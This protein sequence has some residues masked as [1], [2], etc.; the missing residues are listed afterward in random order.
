MPLVNINNRGLKLKLKF[1]L[2][3]SLVPVIRQT[4]KFPLYVS[5]K[6]IFYDT[7]SK[8]LLNYNIYREQCT[9]SK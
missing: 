1:L 5:R 8:F 3:K 2:S 9:I 7:F 6:L 4:V